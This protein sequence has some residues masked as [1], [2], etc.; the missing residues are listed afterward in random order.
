MDGRLTVSLLGNVLT[1]TCTLNDQTDRQLPACLWAY[2]EQE[3]K[4][5]GRGRSVLAPLGRYVLAA[6]GHYLANV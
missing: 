3:K 1:F 6:H 2:R 4:G 5:K